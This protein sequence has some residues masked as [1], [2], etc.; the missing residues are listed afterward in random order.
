MANRFPSILMSAS[1]ATLT[2]LVPRV[3]LF[4][5]YPS[6]FK[7]TETLNQSLKNQKFLEVNPPLQKIDEWRSMEVFLSIRISLCT[8][9]T[10]FS[11]LGQNHLLFSSAS[12]TFHASRHF[13]LDLS[14]SRKAK[15]KEEKSLFSLFWRFSFSN[16]IFQYKRWLELFFSMAFIA[17]FP[18]FF[19]LLPF[20]FERQF[21]SG[22]PT[23]ISWVCHLFLLLTDLF[24]C[25][26]N[27]DVF[28][29]VTDPSL[30]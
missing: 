23:N 22:F 5:T 18:S 29:V 1:K 25:A 13:L 3:T 10:V 8:L 6:Q 26:V 16:L 17:A 7:T 21:L 9:H 20:P 2:I 14:F 11:L 27:S 24:F 19:P 28:M 12:K 4:L 15:K 30:L